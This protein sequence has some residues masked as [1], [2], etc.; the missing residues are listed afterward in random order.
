MEASCKQSKQIR[1][2]KELA[3]ALIKQNVRPSVIEKQSGLSHVTV[4]KLRKKIISEN[5]ELANFKTN[6]VDWFNELQF[7]N[8]KIV[9]AVDTNINEEKI[10]SLTVT[11][12]NKVK[13]SAVWT[14][15]VLEDKIQRLQG[16]FNDDSTRTVYNFIH[17]IK[18]QMDNV[19]G[20]KPE[21]KDITPDNEDSLPPMPLDYVKS[22]IS[23]GIK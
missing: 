17:N 21:P 11:Q 9:Q 5:Q 1:P 23:N 14:I 20:N 15:G 6:K 12:Q 19:G 16:L 22:N 13:S 7:R 18:I 4:W 8:A 10:N 3:I 2:N